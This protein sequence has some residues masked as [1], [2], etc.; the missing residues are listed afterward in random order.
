MCELSGQLTEGGG[1]GEWKLKLS[2]RV[3]SL[4]LVFS[5]DF[6]I[7]ISFQSFSFF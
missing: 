7:F 4:V 3:S 6:F 2:F 1:G 5:N